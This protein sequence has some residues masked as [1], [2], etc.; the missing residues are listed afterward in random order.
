MLTAA[1]DFLHREIGIHRVFYHTFET[2]RA[3]K[4]IYRDPPRS[5]YTTLPR[6]FCFQP[7]REAP[8]MLMESKAWQRKASAFRH[9]P[10]FNLLEV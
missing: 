8:R 7:T 10:L 6:R 3:F 1:L 2:G 4:G 9:V 5:L